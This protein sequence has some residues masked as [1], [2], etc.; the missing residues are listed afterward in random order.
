MRDWI[1]AQLAAG[2]PAFAGSHMSGTLALKQELLNELLGRWLTE[3]A[4][5]TPPRLPD[6]A[7][8]KRVVKGAAVRAEAGRLLIDF[9]IA[10]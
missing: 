2:L 8:V 7:P 3:S 9:T 4:P 6:L 10:V 5:G 1:E